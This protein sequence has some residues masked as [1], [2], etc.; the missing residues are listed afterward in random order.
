M[1]SAR[2]SSSCTIECLFNLTNNAGCGSPF[3]LEATQLVPQTNKLSLF[4]D[5]HRRLLDRK[6]HENKKETK[7]PVPKLKLG[8]RSVWPTTRKKT[9]RIGFSGNDPMTGAQLK[10][11][12][13]QAHKPVPHPA[14]KAEASELIDKM[15]DKAGV[16]R[17]GSS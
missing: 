17:N 7:S 11:L 2:I 16:E 5:L 14:N 4:V 13:E 3:P 6:R 9:P 1:I 8:R 12:A 15:R 10:N